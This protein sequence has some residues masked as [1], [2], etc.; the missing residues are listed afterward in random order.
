MSIHQSLLLPVANP[1][2]YS[3]PFAVP[4][5]VGDLVRIPLDYCLRE[6]IFSVCSKR[7][8]LRVESISVCGR[9][10]RVKSLFEPQ[11]VFFVESSEA[12]FLG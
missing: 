7:I 11:I 1:V 2:F 10:L 4:F 6:P 9:V 8:P 5:E 12:K 3:P